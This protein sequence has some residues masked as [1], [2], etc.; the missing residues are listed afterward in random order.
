MTQE[1]KC[2]HESCNCMTTQKYCSQV[3]EDAKGFTDL[4]CHCGHATCNN[5]AASS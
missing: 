1:K 2:A 3:C 4:M 5:P